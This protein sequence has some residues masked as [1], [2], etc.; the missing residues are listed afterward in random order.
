MFNR[1]EK[2]LLCIAAFRI[3]RLNKKH[4]AHKANLADDYDAIYNAALADAKQRRLQQWA[5][6]QAA[7]TYIRL[8]EQYQDCVFQ[9]LK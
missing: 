9:N 7:K 8:D 6:Q 5:A 2:K 3:V 1:L 4:P